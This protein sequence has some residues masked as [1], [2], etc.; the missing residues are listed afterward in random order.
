MIDIIIGFK[1]CIMIPVKDGYTFE[2]L[3]HYSHFLLYFTTPAASPL[4]PRAFA[5]RGNFKKLS[6]SGAATTTF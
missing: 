5:P 6:T 4:A 3:Q 1:L 2:T